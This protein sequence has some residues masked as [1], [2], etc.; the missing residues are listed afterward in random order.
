[1]P[2]AYRA[3]HGSTAV[4]VWGTDLYADGELHIV[5]RVVRHEPE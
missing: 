2:I 5:L 3:P 4:H 1:M